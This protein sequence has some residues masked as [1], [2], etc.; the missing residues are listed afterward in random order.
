MLKYKKKFMNSIFFAFI[1]FLILSIIFTFNIFLKIDNWGIAD[2]DGFFFYYGV[3][4]K[5]IIEYHQ[6]PLWNPYYCGGN[7]L[8]AHPESLF[9]SPSFIFVLLFG[10][11]RGIKLSILIHT[12]L[13][14]FGFFFLS[15]KIGLKNKSS[16][17]PSIVFMLSGIYSL[18]ISGGHATWQAMA[19]LPFVFLFYL[20]GIPEKKYILISA[21][22]L[23]FIFFQAHGYLFLFTI[24]FLSLYS[25]F[26]TIQTRKM[27][28]LST[29]FFLL[30]ITFLFG[31]I[32]FI[33]TI[34]FI[35]DYP[36]EKPLISPYDYK[37]F[38]NF[39]FDRQISKTLESILKN[40]EYYTYIGIFPFILF[41]IGMLFNFKKMWPLIITGFIFLT[42]SFGFWSSILI[43]LPLFQTLHVISRY[44][45]IFIFV[46]S[47]FAGF[48]FSKIEKKCHN[49]I[50]SLIIAFIVIDLI[51]VNGSIFQYAFI[52][53]PKQVNISTS[54]YQVNKNVS[55]TTY[56]LYLSFLGNVGQINSK[57]IRGE[58]FLINKTNVIPKYIDNKMNSEYKGEAFLLI[59]GYANITFFSPNE[60]KIKFN[61][62]KENI[63]ILNQNFYK[64]WNTNDGRKVYSTKGM[65]STTV[66]PED[67]EIVFFYLP[68][69]FLI[70]LLIST[71]SAIFI[72]LLL[73]YSNIKII[74]LKIIN[75][76]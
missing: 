17:I 73:T 40:W 32:K 38:L 18:N 43:N 55:N 66:Y 76:L 41:S 51:L 6:I 52:I 71:L 13:G 70:G 5:T 24:L 23:L 37:T 68:E 61:T 25:F 60:V 30:L 11:V 20:K 57:E 58:G 72:L 14:M 21:I 62:T 39:L 47:I 27:R 50:S 12:F 54:F 67:H 22:F 42:I 7:V 4:L 44:I 1:F 31:A 15:K 48:G 16:Y 3:P 35:M 74:L 2:W 10:V 69:S 49:L 29:V 19:W 46:A 36:R 9:F 33:P 63:L 26:K 56:D 8:L 64:G 28:F 59:E 53:P 45:V 65:V 34:E 75:R